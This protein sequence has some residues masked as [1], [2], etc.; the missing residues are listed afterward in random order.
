MPGRGD[1]TLNLSISIQ[2]VGLN[3]RMVESEHLEDLA[4]ES[5]PDA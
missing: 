5:L 4:G 2:H 1:H 3:L